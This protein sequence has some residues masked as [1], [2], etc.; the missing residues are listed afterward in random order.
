HGGL[1]KGPLSESIYWGCFYFFPWLRMSPFSCAGHPKEIQLISCGRGLVGVAW[2]VWLGGRD[3]G[4]I[5][6]KIPFPPHPPN[7]LS[8]SILL[9]RAPKGDPV[10]QLW[11]WLGGCGLVGMAWWA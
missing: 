10:D 7:M 9:C 2:W 11:A 6:C 8:S 5:Y 3:R 1:R 4:R